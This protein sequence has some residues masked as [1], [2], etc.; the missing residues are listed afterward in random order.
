MK[1]IDTFLTELQKPSAFANPRE[2]SSFRAT[3][4]PATAWLDRSAIKPESATSLPITGHKADV[5]TTQD[6]LRH[7]SSATTIDLYTQSPMAQRIS[8][9]ESVLNVILKQSLRGDF[10]KPL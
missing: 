4:V 9:Q 1:P 6:I 8:A 2:I 5:R 3:S 10:F 7:S